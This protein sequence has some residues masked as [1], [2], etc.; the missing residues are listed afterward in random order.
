MKNENRDDQNDTRER[1]ISQ[2][3]RTD[4]EKSGCKIWGK[5]VENLWNFKVNFETI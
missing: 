4:M 1:Q 2:T 5:F 3:C